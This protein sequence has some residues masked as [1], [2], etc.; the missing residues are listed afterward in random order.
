MTSTLKTIV[1][2]LTLVSVA[3]TQQSS[4]SSRTEEIELERKKKEAQL[5]PEV[6]TKTEARFLWF[7]EARILEK[8]SYGIGGLRVRLG[9]LVTGSGFASTLR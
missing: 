7:R 9:A 2:F 4:P 3:Y 8:F 1:C 6:V 5:K